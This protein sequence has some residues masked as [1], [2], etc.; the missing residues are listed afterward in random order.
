MHQIILTL[1]ENLLLTLIVTSLDNDKRYQI[2]DETKSNEDV[3][4]QIQPIDLQEKGF[5]AKSGDDHLSSGASYK[6]IPY[7]WFQQAANSIAFYRQVMVNSKLVKE[8]LD[9]IRRALNPEEYCG[10]YVT[11]IFCQ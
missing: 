5:R 2:S 3:S 4:E 1:F 7:F 9:S 11:A 8:E 10:V 6:Q